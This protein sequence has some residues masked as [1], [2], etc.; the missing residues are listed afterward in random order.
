MAIPSGLDGRPIEAA[1]AQAPRYEPDPL[2]ETD[3]SA[4]PYD[5]EQSRAIA[6]RLTSLGYLEPTG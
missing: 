6:A 3:P 4:V 5:D 1:L 2:A